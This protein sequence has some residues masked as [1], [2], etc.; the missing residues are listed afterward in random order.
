MRITIVIPVLNDPR[1]AGAIESALSQRFDVRHDCEIIVVD[2]SDDDA[3][4]AIVD[5]YAERVTIVRPDCRKGMYHARNVGLSHA[6]GDV[7]GFLAADDRYTN[8][9]LSSALETF[10]RN[11]GCA[12]V[13]GRTVVVDNRGARVRNVKMGGM[14]FPH[15]WLG[16]FPADPSIF[17]DRSVFDGSGRY[18]EDYRIAGDYEF[19]TRVAGAGL[20]HCR[21]DRTLVNMAAGGRSQQDGNGGAL[22]RFRERMRAEARNRPGLLLLPV[23]AGALGFVVSRAA[24][25][26]PD[27]RC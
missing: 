6:S 2:D 15:S 27:R 22:T 11:P 5:R 21:V 18:V 20:E 1:V 23:L 16:M 4:I 8:G 12:S 10:A 24:R 17:W 26:L 13:Y 9:A 3:T 25:K 14:E 19:L 7:V